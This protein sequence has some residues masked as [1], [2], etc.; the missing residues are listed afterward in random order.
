MSLPVVRRPSGEQ[1]PT[2]IE[3][4]PRDPGQEIEGTMDGVRCSQGTEAFD[5][6]RETRVCMDGEGGSFIAYGR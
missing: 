3:L 2:T 4:E 6:A 1:S 5:D